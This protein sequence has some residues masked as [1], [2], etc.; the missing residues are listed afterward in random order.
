MENRDREPQCADYVSRWTHEADMARMERTNARLM[1]I[2]LVLLL[3]IGGLVYER[4]QWATVTTTV[5]AEQTTDGGG[6][7]YAVGGDFGG[8][9]E[10]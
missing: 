10:S 2:I 3:A 6:N 5:E 4:L 8:E 9:T 7:N 1:A